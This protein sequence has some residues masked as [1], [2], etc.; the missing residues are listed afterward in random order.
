MHTDDIELSSS[1][2]LKFDIA[3]SQHSSCDSLVLARDCQM[4]YGYKQSLTFVPFQNNCCTLL[5]KPFGRDHKRV[6]K[7]QLVVSKVLNSLDQES[8]PTTS[9]LCRIDLQIGEQEKEERQMSEV[10]VEPTP[11]WASMVTHVVK[12]AT[13]PPVTDEQPHSTSHDEVSTLKKCDPVVTADKRCRG[14]S[15]E[16]ADI[17][18]QPLH[19]VPKPSHKSSATNSLYSKT[20]DELEQALENSREILL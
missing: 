6:S 17:A 20:K 11:L 1:S 5:V 15:K 8:K 4:E 14:K 19:N 18:D 13:P 3:Q 2:V 16:P 9:V 7:G 10:V 12:L